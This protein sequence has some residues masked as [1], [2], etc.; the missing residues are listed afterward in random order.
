MHKPSRRPIILLNNLRIRSLLSLNYCSPCHV[1]Q[2]QRSSFCSRKD[3]NTNETWRRQSYRIPRCC[4]PCQAPT[5][6][7]CSVPS[8]QH[9]ERAFLRALTL[10]RN[11]IRGA[12][13]I[14]LAR[15]NR[16]H[17]QRCRACQLTS[18]LTTIREHSRFQNEQHVTNGQNVLY[19][20][21]RGHAAIIWPQGYWANRVEHPQN[22][23]PV[24]QS[25]IPR[26]ASR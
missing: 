17:Y 19:T 18:I 11:Q 14:T 20:V 1:W 25:A 22:S 5:G 2:D 16:A 7:V 23:V 12:G 8:E 13:P 6:D 21:F 24:A 9:G 4:Q 3:N 26:L 15:K 10:Q